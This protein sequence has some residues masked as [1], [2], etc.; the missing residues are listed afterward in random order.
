MACF[1]LATCFAACGLAQPAPQASAGLDSLSDDK[2][3][4][5]LAIRGLSSL[6]D[7]A[8]EVNKVPQA[9]QE[10]RRAILALQTLT[11]PTKKLSNKDRQELLIKITTGI[12]CV[13]PTMRDPE[14]ILTQANVLIDQGEKRD[15]NTLEYWGENPRTQ[16][17]LRPI[18]EAVTKILD[19][20]SESASLE[21]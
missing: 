3:M 6:L 15:V 17:Q 19:K 7:R 12:E 11:D 21:R 1:V 14:A 18:V 16:G 5:E 8:F 9:E 4:N 10:S 13:L 20:A 2:L